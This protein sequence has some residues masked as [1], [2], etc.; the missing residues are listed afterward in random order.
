MPPI[1]HVFGTQSISF[2]FLVS[3]TLVT[4]YQIVTC[5]SSLALMRLEENGQPPDLSLGE[6]VRYHALLSHI[7]SS[8][9]VLLSARRHLPS[10]R[11]ALIS[12][13][14][15]LC[16]TRSQISSASF[17]SSSLECTLSQAAHGATAVGRDASRRVVPTR[18]IT[19]VRVLQSGVWPL[20]DPSGILFEGCI[21]L[22]AIVLFL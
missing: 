1:A 10:N 22:V 7:W 19:P 20:R 13:M 12:R 5:S 21:H 18:L 6:G 15:P 8:G 16:R 14:S 11:F 2:S 4:L 17:S 9:Q 3:F